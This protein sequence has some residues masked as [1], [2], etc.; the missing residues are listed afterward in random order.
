[1]ANEINRRESLKLAAMGGVGVLFASA[2]PG[3]PHAAGQDD[4]YFVQMSDTVMS[5]FSAESLK[6]LPGSNS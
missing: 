1:M 5:K 2:L 4:C 3:I 6:P